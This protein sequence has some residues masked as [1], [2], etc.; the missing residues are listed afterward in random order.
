[1][2]NGKHLSTE[3]ATSSVVRL[4]DRIHRKSGEKPIQIM[5]HQILG[6]PSFETNYEMIRLF[7]ENKVDLVELQL[8]FSEP[9]ADG[10]VFLRANQASLTNGTTTQQCL[11]FAKRVAAEFPNLSFLFMTYYNVIFQYGI[12]KFIAECSTIGIHGLIVPDAFP[13]ESSEFMATCRDYQ[14]EPILIAT[15][16]TKDVRLAY[17]ADETGGFIYCAA[18]KGVTGS[19]TSFGDE[20]DVFLKRVRSFAKTPIAVGFGIQSSADVQFLKGKCDI[21]IVG[22]QLLNVLEE[23][24]LDGVHRF[25]Q[26]LTS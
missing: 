19:K 12:E 13:D 1:M 8:P 5:T 10:P 15:P 20:T 17:L 3:K 9:I 16:Y 7:N 25:L 24:G 14:V 26:S 11:D 6:Y 2:K 21:A 22:T 23:D 4:E 18:R